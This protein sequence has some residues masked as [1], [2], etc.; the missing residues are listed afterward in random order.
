[1]RRRHTVRHTRSQGTA[2][3]E[4]RTR[5]TEELAILLLQ[6]LVRCTSVANPH[7]CTHPSHSL[8]CLSWKPTG[9][10]SGSGN[11]VHPHLDVRGEGTKSDRLMV[12]LAEGRAPERVCEVRLAQVAPETTYSSGHAG[13]H[14]RRLTA[15]EH[16]HVRGTPCRDENSRKQRQM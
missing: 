15:R 11:R 14:S 4:A 5:T 13:V 16:V 3:M 1:M 2:Q 7:V 9:G 10:P 8:P 12:L 6:V